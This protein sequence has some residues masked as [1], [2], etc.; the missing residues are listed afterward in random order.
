MKV[1]AGE[2]GENGEEVLC[3]V[4]RERVSRKGTDNSDHW[5]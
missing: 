4:R 3:K 1:W 2:W 5:M